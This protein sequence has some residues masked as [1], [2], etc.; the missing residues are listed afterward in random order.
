MFSIGEMMEMQQAMLEKYKDQWEH[1]SP[2]AGRNHLL[3]M[4][5]EIGEVID[6]IKKH[7]DEAA[8]RDSALRAHFVEELADVLNYC[9]QLA[10]KLE[11]D[12][13]AIVRKKM[14]KNALKYPVEKSRGRSDKY[15]QL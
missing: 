10:V 1:F 8:C 4:I 12:P 7:G 15:D 2:G 11:L 9:L 5:G 14:K 3:W 13:V 6:V